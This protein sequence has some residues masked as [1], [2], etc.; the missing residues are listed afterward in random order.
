[1]RVVVQ[2]KF[3][4]PA[5]WKALAEE[6]LVVHRKSDERRNDDVLLF[7]HGLGGG[8]YSTWGGFPELLFTDMPACDIA[9]YSYRTL[10]GRLKF[11]RSVPFEQEARTLAGLV[12]ESEYPHVLLVGHSMG[13]LLIKAVVRELVNTNQLEALGKVAGLL[14]MATPQAGSL[15]VP[16]F[17]SWLTVDTRALKA[18]GPLVRDTAQTFQDRIHAVEGEWMRDRFT[19]P[20]WAVEGSSDIWVDKLS[21]GLGLESRRKLSVRGS[22]TSIVKPTTAADDAYRFVHRCAL[23]AFEFA[24][25]PVPTFVTDAASQGQIETSTLPAPGVVIDRQ[26]ALDEVHAFLEDPQRRLMILHG[27][28]GIGKTVAVARG[29]ADQRVPFDDRLWIDCTRSETTTDVF[30]ARLNEMLRRNGDQQLNGIWNDSRLPLDI[31]IDA[32]IR[33]FHRPYLIVL[34]DFDTWLDENLRLRN[35]EIRRTLLRI[36]SSTHNSKVLVISRTRPGDIGPDQIP[37]GLSIERELLGLSPDD[38]GALLEQTGVPGL[39]LTVVERITEHFGGNPAALKLFGRL[40]ATRH[41]EPEQ[42]LQRYNTVPG[43][44]PLLEQV[45]AGLETG[46]LH[47]LGQLS[48]FRLP[49][50][51]AAAEDPSTWDEESIGTLID[52][53][54]VQFDPST[55]RFLVAGFV[56]D[57]VIGE[58]T[59]PQLRDAHARAAAHY[60]SLKPQHPEQFHDAA[61]MFEEGYHLLRCGQRDGAADRVASAAELLIGWGYIDRADEELTVLLEAPLDNRSR[62]RCRWL[63]GLAQDVRGDFDAALHSMEEVR[64]AVTEDEEPELVAR[65]LHLTGRIGNVRR[66]FHS[67]REAFERCIDLCRRGGLSQPLAAVYL[68]KGWAEREEGAESDVVLEAFQAALQVAEEGGDHQ[69]RVAAHREI[70]FLLALRLEPSP[71]PTEHVARVARSN[72]EQALD[73]ALEHGLAKEIG[74]AYATASYAHW[75][76][77]ES[78][79]AEADARRAI[80]IAETLGDPSLLANARANLAGA[81]DQR[82]DTK[83]AIKAY[84]DAIEGFRATNNTKGQAWT[85]RKLAIARRGAGSTDTAIDDFRTAL[86][87]AEREGFDDLIG[88]LRADLT[89]PDSQGLSR[90]DPQ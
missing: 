38:A 40:V 72:L 85:I 3:E 63:L 14:L 69:T 2:E 20:V 23:A 58:M 12:R 24:R 67:A 6:A 1:M 73:I 80:E 84:L 18:H 62:A 25:A 19:L 79:Q 56:R 55:R 87:I 60:A 32:A 35:D 86:V 34:D 21:S 7:V 54:L 36:F 45:V 17:L 77:H 39:Q 41:W 76:W 30:L 47:V 61:M 4:R 78:D 27:L 90:P 70:A 22:H 88:Q 51:R 66:D 13:G 74:G 65:S 50:S 89:E 68:D 81:L 42:L 49:P 53:S 59:D 33:A 52:H 37:T 8:R 16:G 44:A 71:G 48:V 28:R 5:D 75:V 83:A 31:K 57:F 29:I 26:Q 9:L 11:W 46:P 82:G 10:A 64:R 43:F 15:R